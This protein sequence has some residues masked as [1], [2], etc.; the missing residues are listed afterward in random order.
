L[1]GRRAVAF[2]E[3][4]GVWAMGVGCGGFVCGSVVHVC[5]RVGCTVWLFS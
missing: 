4:W 5:F 2:R 3:A 1:V